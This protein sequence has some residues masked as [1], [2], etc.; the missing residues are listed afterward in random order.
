MGKTGTKGLVALIKQ[1]FP[2]EYEEAKKLL[3]LPMSQI[4]NTWCQ[5]GPIQ[6]YVIYHTSP[7]NYSGNRS[8]KHTASIQDGI[9][10]FYSFSLMSRL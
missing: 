10:E 1:Y 7:F 2:D 4:A 6:A 3:N 9:A 5:F 8:T